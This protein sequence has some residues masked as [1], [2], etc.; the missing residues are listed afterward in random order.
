[1]CWLKQITNST[2]EAVTQTEVGV[3]ASNNDRDK[4]KVSIDSLCD[5]FSAYAQ[6]ALHNKLYSA[7]AVTGKRVARFAFGE[8]MTLHASL[9]TSLSELLINYRIFMCLNI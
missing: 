7:A 2:G 6:R 4:R 5:I 1:M 3:A 8:P 9:A